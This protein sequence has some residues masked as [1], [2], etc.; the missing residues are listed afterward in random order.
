MNELEEYRKGLMER[1]EQAA[2]EFRAACLAVKDPNQALEPGG[3]N[4]HQIAVHTRDADHMVYGMRAR[5]TALEDNPTFA[6]F[7]GEVYMEEHYDPHE[8]LS[9]LLDGFVANVEGLIELLRALPAE[10]W[11]RRSSHATLGSG[12]TLQSWV[13]KDLAHIEEHLG[14]LKKQTHG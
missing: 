6:N 2:R 14:T 3:W 1:L 4:V 9:E 5:R 11:A 7:N 12:L 10:S 13:E 8:S